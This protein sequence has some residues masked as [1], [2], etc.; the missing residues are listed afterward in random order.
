MAYSFVKPESKKRRR[1]RE[2]IANMVL[3]RCHSLVG[4]ANEAKLSTRQMSRFLTEQKMLGNTEH[5]IVTF[6]RRARV[7]WR[8]VR[9]KVVKR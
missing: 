1:A 3:K 9:G 8:R 5:R 6:K 4:L 2:T 7:E